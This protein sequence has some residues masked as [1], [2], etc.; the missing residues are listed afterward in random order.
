[1]NTHKFLDAR[2]VTLLIAL[3][4]ALAIIVHPAFLLIGFVITLVALI[5]AVA[6]AVSEPAHRA[7][8]QHRHPCR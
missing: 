2:T 4:I 5:E 1:M 3:A 6:Q 7:T 8:P